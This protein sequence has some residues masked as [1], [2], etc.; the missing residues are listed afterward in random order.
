MKEKWR[1]LLA[2][3]M[4]IGMAVSLAACGS[5]KNPGTGSEQVQDAA[6]SAEEAD[7]TGDTTDSQDVESITLSIGVPYSDYGNGIHTDKNLFLQELKEKTG[8]ELEFVV[9]DADSYALMCAGGDLPDIIILTTNTPG[10]VEALVASGGIIPLD[11]LIEEYGQHIKANIPKALEAVRDKENGDKIYGMP[12]HVSYPGTIPQKNAA[13]GFRARYDIYKEIGSPAIATQDD[14][15]NVL[16][17]MQDYQREKTGEDDIYC[18]GSFTDWGTWPYYICY[19]F[20]YGLMDTKTGFS[21]DRV[22]GELVNNYTDSDS[23]Y[24]DGVA[25]FNRAYQMGLFDPDGLMQ[26]VAQYYDKVATGKYIATIYAGTPD[27]SLLGE[28]AIMTYLPGTAF[29]NVNETYSM[30]Y[31]VGYQLEAARAISANC[32]YPERAMQVMDYIDSPEG[33]RSLMNGVR[34]EDWDVVDGVP[35]LIGP[36]LEA[37]QEG[38]QDDYKRDRTGN[39]V[40]MWCLFSG[41]I[42]LDD[43]YPVDLTGTEEFISTTVNEAELAFAHDF[44]SNL[45]YPGQVYEKWIQEG[46][47]TDV[48]TDEGALKVAALGN[49]SEEASRI[50]AEAEDYLASNI[51]KLVFAASDEE[52]QKEKD[53][54][55]KKFNELGFAT[56]EEEMVALFEEAYKAYEEMK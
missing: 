3:S 40:C 56:V 51:A 26:K 12:T 32:Q 17:Q 42:T 22:T 5:E 7:Q 39:P 34:G 45:S 27:R 14:Y 35:Q 47:V 41:N 44:D 13:I 1:K 16:K 21:Y 33:A 24:W 53:N 43:G 23:I 30:A 20:M 31:P 4:A 9:Y 38:S 54:M 8:V 25:F 28:H 15:L 2:C 18:F 10:A 46:T 11:D 49:L 50:S 19:P 52:F 55:I 37:Y 48:T 36:M 29:P 6:T